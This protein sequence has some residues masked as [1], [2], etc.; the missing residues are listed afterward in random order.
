MTCSQC[1]SDVGAGS[2]A[3]PHCGAP[4][5]GFGTQEAQ[6]QPPHSAQVP[7]PYSAQEYSAQAPPPQSAPA[8]APAFNF[9]LKRLTRD[10]QL[11]GGASLLLLISLFLPWYTASFG[12]ASASLSGTGGHDFLWIV[13]ILALAAVVYVILKAGFETLPFD[14]PLSPDQLLLV[15]TGVN[16]VLVLI[17]FLLKPGTGATLINIS[18]GWG[19]GAFVGLICAIVAFVPLAL[20]LVRARNAGR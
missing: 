13:F 10:D 19:I 14:L 20:P 17:A 18:V 3:C 9:D 2:T 7:P 11:V 5:P 1:G 12:G 4:Q 16:L 8:A 6:A 15:L